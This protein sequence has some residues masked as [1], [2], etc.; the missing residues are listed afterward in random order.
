MAHTDGGSAPK[1]HAKLIEIIENQL[2]KAEP[3]EVGATLVRL[4]FL[5]HSRDAAIR[6][7]AFALA[8]EMKQMMRDGRPF[9]TAAYVAKLHLLP[10]LVEA[11]RE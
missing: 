8:I 5:G 10:G 3:R 7:I 1:V 4:S 9:D 6:M 2:R 11:H